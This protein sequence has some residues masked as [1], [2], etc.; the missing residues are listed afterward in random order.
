MS[1]QKLRLCQIGNLQQYGE[2][3]NVDLIVSLFGTL[4]VSGKRLVWKQGQ[5]TIKNITSKT[6][7]YSWLKHHRVTFPIV[8]SK[9]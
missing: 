2:N 3:T 7:I 4:S 5:I 9:S 8:A 1:T 6:F